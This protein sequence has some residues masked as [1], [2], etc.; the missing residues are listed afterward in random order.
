MYETRNAANTA[1]ITYSVG[2]PL[3]SSV[4]GLLTNEVSTSGVIIGICT[5]APSTASPTLG[6]DERI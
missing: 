3:Y 5:K 4:Y 1:D 6:L 2:D